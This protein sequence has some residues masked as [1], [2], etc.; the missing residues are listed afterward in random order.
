VHERDIVCFGKAFRDG[1]SY[2]FTSIGV[3]SPDDIIDMTARDLT[4][5]GKAE[6]LVR[7]IMHAKGSI[8]SDKTADKTADK[9]AEKKPGKKSDKKSDKK[10]EE[11]SVD[12]LVF[13]VFQVKEDSIKRIFAAETGRAFD[14]NLLLGGL[15]FVESGQGLEIELLAGRAHGFTKSTYPFPEDSSPSG[16]FEPLSLPWGSLGARRY[17]FDGSRYSVQ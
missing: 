3:A 14:G 17:R 6:I 13:M 4:G 12:R 5:D 15:R 11:K 9:K 16:G 10:G 1:Q 8:D 7:A 2:V